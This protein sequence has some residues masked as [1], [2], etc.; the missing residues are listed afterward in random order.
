[1]STPQDVLGGAISA[2]NDIILEPVNDFFNNIFSDK[3]ITDLPP[4]LQQRI[5]DIDFEINMLTGRLVPVPPCITRRG[6]GRFVGTFFIGS[7]ISF[8]TENQKARAT[9][10]PFEQKISQ[11]KAEREKIIKEFGAVASTRK[12]ILKLTDQINGLINTKPFTA[13]VKA[14][15][16]NKIAEGSKA[17]EN[18]LAKSIKIQQSDLT[19]L[20]TT[21]KAASF[22]LQ[23]PIQT[24]NNEIDDI[25]K[26]VSDGLFGAG[27]IFADAFEAFGKIMIDGLFSLFEFTPEKLTETQNMFNQFAQSQVS[28]K[29]G[30]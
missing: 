11:L 24:Q 13:Q 8:C 14:E 26:S 9:N 18:I 17:I 27:A 29:K 5:K 19:K 4:E 22:A 23:A 16:Q 30:V 12:A 28:E 21:L 3:V 7:T 1:L 25:L 20:Q 6:N 15:L 10:A 2:F